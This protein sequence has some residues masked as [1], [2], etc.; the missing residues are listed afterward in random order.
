MHMFVTVLPC[1]CVCLCDVLENR[2][3]FAVHR[4]IHTPYTRNSLSPRARPAQLVQV[5]SGRNRMQAFAMQGSMSQA[6]S[7]AMYMLAIACTNFAALCGA[8]AAASVLASLIYVINARG[9]V[10]E[11]RSRR[12]HFMHVGPREDRPSPTT[13][14][15]HPG[16]LPR[17]PDPAA[18]L[19]DVADE[20][21]VLLHSE[22]GSERRKQAEQADCGGK[23]SRASQA[24]A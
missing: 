23:A 15:F 16:R 11:R 19:V 8:S 21:L 22:E 20:R 7:C 12:R 6:A 10:S 13:S 2:R 14:A 5:R 9:G 17:L 3:H 4:L 24:K 18:A 1:V